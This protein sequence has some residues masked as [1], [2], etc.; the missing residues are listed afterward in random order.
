MIVYH[1]TEHAEAILRKGFRENT[2]NYMTNREH[3]G[4]WFSDVPFEGGGGEGARGETTLMLDIPE[5]VLAPYWWDGEEGKTYRECCCPAELVNR[6][7]PPK[8]HSDDWQGMTEEQLLSK[9][10]A[11]EG[12]GAVKRAERIREK[13]PVLKRHGLLAAPEV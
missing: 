11:L 12:I 2:A 9:A 5:D 4:V 1:R 8:I 7:G 13:I 6:F 3:T 10:A